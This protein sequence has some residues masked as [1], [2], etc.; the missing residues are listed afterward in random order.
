MHIIFLEALD[1]TKHEAFTYV[2]LLLMFNVI[3][4]KDHS[5]DQKYIG[6]GIA[7]VL[8]NSSGCCQTDVVIVTFDNI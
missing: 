8:H 5:L 3:R 6:L 4:A 2:K 1:M 7:F